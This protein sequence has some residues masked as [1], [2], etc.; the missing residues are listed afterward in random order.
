MAEIVLGAQPAIHF[1]VAGHIDIDEFALAV[2]IRH[3]AVQA[4]GG[5]ALPQLLEGGRQ[6]FDANPRPAQMP[7]EK[8]AVRE[9]H[10]VVGPDIHE[11]ALAI[12]ALEKCLV[13]EGVLTM[14]LR[15]RLHRCTKVRLGYCAPVYGLDTLP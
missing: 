1:S 8:Q 14:L 6:R 13:D 10:A 12:L 11:I 4:N 9:R 7:L 2:A 15:E 3:G 5:S